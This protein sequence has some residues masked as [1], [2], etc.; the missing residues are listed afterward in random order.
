M[1]PFH[2]SFSEIPSVGSTYA[3]CQV[4]PPV[5]GKYQLFK[6]ESFPAKEKRGSAPEQSSH[7]HTAL[8][9]LII[10]KINESK[11]YCHWMTSRHATM[12]LKKKQYFFP[13]IWTPTVLFWL[14]SN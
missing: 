11:N 4:F 6:V 8:N 12:W 14:E 10:I 2:V 13:G 7:M 3:S 5:L 1:P 9:K